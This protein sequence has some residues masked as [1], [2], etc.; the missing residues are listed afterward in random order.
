[1]ILILDG[2]TDPHNL[3]ACIRSAE[4]FGAN[5]VIIPKDKCANIT[6]T[7]TKVASGALAVLPVIRV[8]NLAR[9]LTL[10][11]EKGIWIYGAAEEAEG[12]LKLLDLTSSIGVVLGSE[13]KGLRRLT[14]ERC[15]DLFSIPT[16]GMISSLNVSVATG[17]ILYEINRQ[18]T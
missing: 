11:K 1:M 4:V 14:R 3:G 6:P 17:V 12:E 5:L 16:K 2:I 13:G 8:T 15:D 7:V 18:R 10:L 9:T